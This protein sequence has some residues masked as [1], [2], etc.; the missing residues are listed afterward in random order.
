MSDQA[1]APAAAAPVQT[2]APN[3]DP[4]AAY[5]GSVA[6]ESKPVVD[7]YASYGGS[8]APAPKPAN[9]ASE[10]EMFAATTGGN[11][12][13]TAAPAPKVPLPQGM[14]PQDQ[15]SPVSDKLEV[16]NDAVEDA[17][18]DAALG[19]GKGAA[20]TALGATKLTNRLIRGGLNLAGVDPSKVDK[21]VPQMGKVDDYIKAATGDPN[22]TLEAHGIAQ[23]VGKIGE[24][25]AEFMVG[26]EE[27]KALTA[28]E[29]FKALSGA[30]NAVEKY[31]VL[32]RVVT[33]SMR[34]AA[35]G[36]VQN[37]VKTAGENPVGSLKVGALTGAGTAAV[38]GLS[39]AA[40]PAVQKAFKFLNAP[41]DAAE[42]AKFAER[43]SEDARTT[44]NEAA[45]FVERQRQFVNDIAKASK[46]SKEGLT[47]GE[48]AQAVQDDLDK[49]HQQL[50]NNFGQALDMFASHADAAGVK[51]GGADSPLAQAARDILNQGSGLPQN[52][53]DAMGNVTQGL[54]PAKD[55]LEQLAKG[56]PMTWSEASQLQKLLGK[57]AYAITDYTN[58][59]KRV[60]TNLKLAVGDSMAEGAED[61]G[62]PQ[63]AENL[64]N[65]RTDYATTIQQLQDNAVIRALRNKDLD[66]VAK[67]LMSRDTIGDNVTTLRTL[68]DRIGSTHMDDVENEIF[69]HLIDKS[70]DFSSGIPDVDADKLAANFFKIPEQVREQIWGGKLDKFE[71]ALRTSQTGKQAAEAH[72]GYVADAASRMAK[73]AADAKAA[74]AAANSAFPTLVRHGGA[75]GFLGKAAWDTANGDYEKAMKDVGFAVAAEAATGALRQ[76]VVQKA[77]LSTLQWLSHAS[78]NIGTR[79]TS[80]EPETAES[81]AAG[82]QRGATPFGTAPQIGS[83][84]VDEN[85]VGLP[86]N[87]TVAQLDANSPHDLT[88]ELNEAMAKSPTVGVNAPKPQVVQSTVD[89]NLHYE[90]T[91]HADGNTLI[92]NMVGKDGGHIGNIVLSRTSPKSMEVSS[93]LHIGEEGKGLGSELYQSAARQAF[94][95]N[96]ELQEVTQSLSSQPTKDALRTW[97]SMARKGQAEAAQTEGNHIYYRF[98][99]RS[100]GM[101]PVEGTLNERAK[102]LVEAASKQVGN[103]PKAA[104]N[105]H[106]IGD[107]DAMKASIRAKRE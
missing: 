29:K 83:G 57:K 42:D 82:A 24:T 32:A 45:D 72:S 3:V 41:A 98:T 65:L 75:A 52:L 7:P 23:N 91:A 28:A 47:G 36:G 62:Q 101:E 15:P 81:L 86:S 13:T 11:A 22:A 27:L 107:V 102:P 89:P 63:L 84:V 66:G 31:P 43:A 74:V 44:A 70:A 67:L 96:P 39:A 48:L 88:D 60:Y 69:N 94:A 20:E 53:Q 10:A 26:S 1:T 9:P 79:V 6:D 87:T 56:E 95:S 38:E 49:V 14:R 85:Q 78:E 33:N 105:V 5:G 64:R 2:P 8:F 46:A 19:F 103:A 18:A 93:V 59:L 21:W 34:A 55:L 12:T 35:L 92:T 51:V 4:Y 97:I 90:T 77:I 25:V 37:L 71:E 58:P 100:L 30:L 99:R 17:G 73:R 54:E 104:T 106:D 68:L 80:D 16:A 50:T 61:A 40:I 76:P